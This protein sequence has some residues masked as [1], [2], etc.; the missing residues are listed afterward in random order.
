MIKNS[1]LKHI[2]INTKIQHGKPCIK[3]TRTPIYIILEALALD[4]TYEQI[5]KE[6]PPITDNDIHACISYAALLSNEEERIPEIPIT[7]R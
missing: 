4:L 7:I 2:E 1:I 5:K 6:Y 3:G